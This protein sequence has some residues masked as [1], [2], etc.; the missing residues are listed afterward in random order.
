[1]Y[2]AT[3][4]ISTKKLPTVASPRKARMMA[5]SAQKPIEADR[6]MFGRMKKI[7]LKF[8]KLWSPE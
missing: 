8:E 5:E 7:W 6:N 4:H 2:M 1:M 3:R